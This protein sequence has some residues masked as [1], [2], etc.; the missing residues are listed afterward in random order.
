MW[1]P[2]GMGMGREGV[3]GRVSRCRLLYMEWISSKV[4]LHGTEN[5]VQH[6]MINHNGKEYI[7][8]E[9]V[10]IYIYTRTLYIHI[11]YIHY[12]C[13]C[14]CIYTHYTYICITESF[15]CTAVIDTTLEINYTSI[16]TIWLLSQ[17]LIILST[18]NLQL[19]I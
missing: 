5:Y 3:G 18:Y 4:L 13:I 10:Y 14:V 16:K 19:S 11:L 17:L 7:K 2:R 12:T 9:C 6:P 8:K 15:C 1:L